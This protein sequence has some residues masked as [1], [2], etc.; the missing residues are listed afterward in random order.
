MPLDNNLKLER[1]NISHGMEKNINFLELG[2]GEATPFL[3]KNWNL[4]SIE[5]SGQYLVSEGRHS[6][7]YN[8]NTSVYKGSGSLGP[9]TDVDLT[10]Y[11]TK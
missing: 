7:Q 3:L 2:S 9:R 4:T 1:H 8:F 6:Y 10:T 5:E 11:L